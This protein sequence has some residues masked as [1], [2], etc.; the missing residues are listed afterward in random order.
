MSYAAQVAARK[1]A[2]PEK[3]CANSRCLWR[4]TT[5]S[6]CPRHC[7]RCGAKVTECQ[8]GRRVSATREE[9]GRDIA[10]AFDVMKSAGAWVVPSQTGPR[11]YQVTLEGG[12]IRCSCP[13]HRYRRVACKHIYAAAFTVQRQVGVEV[14]S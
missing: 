7:Q 14:R 12:A 13:D 9:R 8:C 11:A 1:A 10:E 3:Y 4:T 6:V 2:H 5:S